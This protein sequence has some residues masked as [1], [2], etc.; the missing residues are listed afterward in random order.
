MHWSVS[1]PKSEMT[2]SLPH[3]KYECHFTFND[4]LSYTFDNSRPAT[5]QSSTVDIFIRSVTDMAN[6]ILIAA[7]LKYALTECQRF[8]VLHIWQS[9]GCIVTFLQNKCIGWWCNRNGLWHSYCGILKIIMIRSSTIF[10]FTHSI[11]KRLHY[12]ITSR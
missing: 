11:I 6:D 12:H 2:C 5:L 1:V 3:H 10:C 9:K 7:S 8:L 4:A